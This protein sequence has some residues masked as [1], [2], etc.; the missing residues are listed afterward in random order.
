MEPSTIVLYSTNKS[1][2]RGVFNEVSRLN[3]YNLL[4]ND[5]DAIEIL[6]QAG[7]DLIKNF[8]TSNPGYLIS[9]PDA[10]L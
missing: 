8:Y 1:T 9:N 6:T 2:V 4:T 7:R 5:I 3:M 10:H